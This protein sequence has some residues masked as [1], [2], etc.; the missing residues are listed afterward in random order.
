ML[1]VTDEAQLTLPLGLRC[2][3]FLP[4]FVQQRIERDLARNALRHTR[5]IA[6]YDE[7]AC[8]LRLEALSSWYLKGMSQWPFYNN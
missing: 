6:A 8:A 4:D 5:F 3:E 1:K 2:R 7:I